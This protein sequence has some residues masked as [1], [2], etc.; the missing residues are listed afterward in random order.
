VWAIKSKVKLRYII[1]RS[2][3]YHNHLG[4]EKNAVT[5]QMMF[6]AGACLAGGELAP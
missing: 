3:A 5:S 1:V 6:E 2:K 4:A